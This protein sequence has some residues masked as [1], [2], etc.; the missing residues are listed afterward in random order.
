[1]LNDLLLSVIYL[2]WLVGSLLSLHPPL[3]FSLVVD[4]LLGSNIMET[5]LT[6]FKYT[7]EGF[8]EA[9]IINYCSSIF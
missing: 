5:R 2:L 9:L 3:S 4:A 7:G 8:G 6:L 1:M